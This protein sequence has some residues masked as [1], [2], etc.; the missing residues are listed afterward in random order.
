MV[1]TKRDI[2]IRNCQ[3]DLGCEKI[4]EARE[5]YIQQV[6]ADMHRWRANPSVCGLISEFEDY[7]ISSEGIR[8]A[9]QGLPSREDPVEAYVD[10]VRFLRALALFNQWGITMEQSRWW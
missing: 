6:Q 8:W 3:Q 5:A 2:H 1:R 10:E 4:G 9:I 7:I